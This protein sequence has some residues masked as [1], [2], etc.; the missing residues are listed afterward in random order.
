MGNWNGAVGRSRKPP[1]LGVTVHGATNIY[2]KILK[3]YFGG[4]KVTRVQSTLSGA[5]PRLTLVCYTT[6]WGST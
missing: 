2:N 4:Q 5:V 1:P 3:I 6:E